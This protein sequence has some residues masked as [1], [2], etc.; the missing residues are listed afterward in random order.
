MEFINNPQ[1]IENRSMA[2]IE[3]HLPQL[4]SLPLGERE[5]IKRVIHTTG[6]LGYGELV[7]I[8]PAAVTS[9]LKAMQASQPVITDV[10]MVKTGIN[11]N[12][13]AKL[14]I[15]VNCYINDPAVVAE[16][17]Q[18]RLTRAMVAMRRTATELTGGIAVIGNAPTALFTLLEMIDQKQTRPAL[19]I[20]TPVGFVGAAESKELLTQYAIP[21]ITV[22][23]TRGGSTVAAAIV[24]ALL[25]LAVKTG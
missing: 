15:T 9:G 4:A 11:K 17:Q 6:D 22:N 16:A 25:H 12:L 5:I 3:E 13:L 19:I 7:Y 21:H 24:N 20:G 1:V 14:N 23:G 18:T 10:N 8:H 2:I